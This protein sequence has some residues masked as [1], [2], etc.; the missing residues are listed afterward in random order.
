MFD[1]F[2]KQG[3]AI[4]LVTHTPATV[5]AVCSRALYVKEGRI[6]ADGE[7]K[8]VTGMY[9]K[10]LLGEQSEKEPDQ[11]TTSEE[12]LGRFQ[13][14]SKDVSIIEGGVR[15]P[16]WAA[17]DIWEYGRGTSR[18]IA[19]SNVDRPEVDDLNVGITIRTVLGVE[20]FAMNSL[21]KRS[22]ASGIASG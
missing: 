17:H 4:L 10:D 1:E 21:S 3:G 18:S 2:R 6:A 7:P 20:L 14:G 12:A 15:G 16:Q 11:P 8:I 9:L 13:Y 19:D 5:N 22:S